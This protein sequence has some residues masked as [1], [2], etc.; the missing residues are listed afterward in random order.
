MQYFCRKGA[1]RP[2]LAVVKAWRKLEVLEVTVGKKSPAL[3]P[4]GS[5][6]MQSRLVVDE[7]NLKRRSTP[8]G[9]DSSE[10]MGAGG[11]RCQ[12]TRSPSAK[13]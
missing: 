1:R 7:S 11:W 8:L 3:E 9:A 2:V 5:E 13:G 6:T 12:Q 4:H 10:P